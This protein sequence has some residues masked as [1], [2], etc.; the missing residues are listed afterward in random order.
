MDLGLQGKAAVV[1]GGSDGIGRAT[2]RALAQAG[3]GV[4]IC[5]RGAQAL[6]ATAT[7]LN[8]ETGA[9]IIPVKADVAQ[10]AELQRVVETAVERFGRLDALVNNAGTSRAGPFEQVT[11]EVW[12]E[13]LDL[14]LFGAIRACRLALPHLRRA[15]GG[16]VVNVLN[17]GAKQPG[18]ASVPTSVSRAAGMALTKSLSKEWA[19]HRVRVNAVMIG[20][21]KSGQHERSWQRQG[22][23]GS[24]ESYYE[25]MARERGVPLG[26]VAQAEEA[27]DLIAFLC[28]PRAAYITGTAINFDG[29]LSAVV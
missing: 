14:K 11:D 22:S 18:P 2:A 5:A 19:A 13:D 6:D 25:N 4:V 20:L 9:T 3:V 26:R 10:P 21:V 23:Q 29:G 12:Q 8:A 1:T 16:S 28:S 7:T 17:I 27:G 15:G 24:L